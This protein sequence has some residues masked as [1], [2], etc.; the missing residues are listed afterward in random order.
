MKDASHFR[1]AENH[2]GVKLE[3]LEGIKEDDLFLMLTYSRK[4]LKCGI[5]VPAFGFN[6]RTGAVYHRSKLN[7]VENVL[8]PKPSCQ[9]KLLPE[10]KE[11][12]MQQREKYLALRA[13]LGIEA[14][15]REMGDPQT[16]GA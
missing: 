13:E 5:A 4:V 6:P 9:F 16:R 8:D 15:G 3:Q 2:F 12:F 10:Q 1:H 7:Y 11:L 14:A